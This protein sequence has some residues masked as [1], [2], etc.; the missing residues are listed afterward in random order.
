MAAPFGGGV[1][2]SHCCNCA[3]PTCDLGLLLNGVKDLGLMPIA[4]LQV[5]SGLVP[6]QELLVSQLQ[7]SRCNCL[8]TLC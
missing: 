4:N 7:L 3:A 2:R 1:T 5:A 8:L 6:V